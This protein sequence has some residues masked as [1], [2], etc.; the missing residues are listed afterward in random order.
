MQSCC[1][2]Q[3]LRPF[4]IFRC[5]RDSELAWSKHFCL[6]LMPS[7]IVSFSPSSQDALVVAY[8]L[9]MVAIN[10]ESSINTLISMKLLYKLFSFFSNPVSTCFHRVKICQ[11]S[12]Y[13]QKSLD[14]T[15]LRPSQIVCHGLG[16][17]L[18]ARC[19][20]LDAGF[21]LKRQQ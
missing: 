5:A 12:H 3:Q 2:I 9:P 10:P 17:H 15:G 7:S 11:D 8:L 14:I 16:V 13:S 1:N 19:S 18:R 21:A 20:G 6:L 4:S